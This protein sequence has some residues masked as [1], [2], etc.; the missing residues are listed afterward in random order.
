[1]NRKILKSVLVILFIILAC[2][3][4]SRN[5]TRSESI[6]DYAQ[7]NKVHSQSYEP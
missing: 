4:A 2:T 3:F 5:L 1:M 6:A 7:K